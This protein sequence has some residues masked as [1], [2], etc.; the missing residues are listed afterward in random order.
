MISTLEHSRRNELP[1]EF[2]GL[3]RADAIWT[4]GHGKRLFGRDEI[5]PFACSLAR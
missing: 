3:F 5:S 2:V 1:A 4:R